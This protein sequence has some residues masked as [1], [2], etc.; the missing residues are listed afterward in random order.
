M[1]V[2]A[3]VLYVKPAAL[4]SSLIASVPPRDPP[5]TG[6]LLTTTKHALP[7]SRLGIS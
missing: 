3:P 2:F 1:V 5:M 7:P 6:R 4:S